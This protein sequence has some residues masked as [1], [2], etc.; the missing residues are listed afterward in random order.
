MKYRFKRTFYLFERNVERIIFS[1]LCPDLVHVASAGEEIVAVLKNEAED[2][3]DELRQLLGY[4]L[5][6]RFRIANSGVIKRKA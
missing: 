3:Y 2:D 6:G 4:Q 1:G 5:A